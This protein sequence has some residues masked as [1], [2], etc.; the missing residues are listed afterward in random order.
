LVA[1]SAVREVSSEAARCLREAHAQRSPAAV[2]PND[3]RYWIVLGAVVEFLRQQAGLTQGELAAK[4][5]VAQSTLS[6]IEK[7]TYRTDVRLFERIADALMPGGRTMADR[8]LT[9][10]IDKADTAVTRVIE[11]IE[12]PQPLDFG[13]DAV[14]AG[15]RHLTRFVLRVQ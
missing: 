5:E 15:I 11:A 8:A 6:R 14:C 13:H 1:L 10:V 3:T 7:G 4:L 12:P 9:R 2:M